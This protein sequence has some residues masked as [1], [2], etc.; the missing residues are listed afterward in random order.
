M[1]KKN[2]AKG[3]IGNALTSV[4][5]DHIV[6]VTNDIFDEEQQEYQQPLNKG[7]KQHFED[8]EK[9][10]SPAIYCK[11]FLNIGQTPAEDGIYL[12]RDAEGDPVQI[13]TKKGADLQRSIPEEGILY[14][15]EGR[16]YV[17]NGIMLIPSGHSYFIFDGGKADSQYGYGSAIGGGNASTDFTIAKRIDCGGARF[18]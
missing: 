4:A 14:T 7:N 9:R 13:V 10:I 2:I 1:A 5:S 11:G 16:A 8:I 3:K 6:A 12:Q 17:F 15:C 18:V